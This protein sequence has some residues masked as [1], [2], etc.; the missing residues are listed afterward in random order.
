MWCEHCHMKA[1]AYSELCVCVCVCIFHRA[2]LYTYIIPWL[3]VWYHELFWIAIT[4]SEVQCVEYG[5][6]VVY[7]ALDL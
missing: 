7:V 1:N 5:H 6:H 4:E 2:Q 3:H